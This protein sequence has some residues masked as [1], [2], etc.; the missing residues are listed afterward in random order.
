MMD[1]SDPKLVIRLVAQNERTRI[2]WK[3]PH[4]KRYYVPA[5]FQDFP[6]RGDMSGGTTPFDDRPVDSD[7]DLAQDSEPE[8]RISIDKL[9]KNMKKG[10][11]FGSDKSACDIYCGEYDENYKIGRQTFSI[12]IKKQHDVILKH[13]RNSN[14]TNV[15]YGAQKTGVRQEF[16]WIM[17]SSC[18]GISVTSARQLKFGVILA[19]PGNEEEL[20][21]NLNL[22]AQFLAE[23]EKSMKP[24]PLPLP[25]PKL[26]PFY[27]VRKDRELGSGGFG[28]VYIVVDASTGDEYAGKTFFGDFDKTEGTILVMQNHV[29]H[30][31][32]SI[33][34]PEV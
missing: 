1:Q 3:D 22:R 30:T 28:K 32:Y 34:L 23:V 17:F 6:V 12:T 31:V 4:N 13:F 29:S 26:R 8:L 21:R 10:W 9:P 15:K 18:K 2:A 24:M 19:K 27:Y 5:S 7:E 33:L 14:W 25:T 20:A 11:V 16:V